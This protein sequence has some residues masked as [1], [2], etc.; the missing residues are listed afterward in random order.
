MKR[1][2]IGPIV[3]AVPTGKWHRPVRAERLVTRTDEPDSLAR[4]PRPHQRRRHRL[5]KREYAVPILPSRDL[6]ETL[7]FFERLGF[8][9]Q[10]FPPEVR[11]YI[12][13][14]RGRIQL[15]LLAAPTTDPLANTASCYVFVAD[16]DR[17]NADWREIG[18]AADPDTGSRLEAPMNTDY[19]MREF[20][21][22]D[23]S[24]NHVR[25]GSVLTQ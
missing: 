6:R 23:P 11:D 5:P 16:A 15:H 18:V 10:A 9:N 25:V 17:V 1:A 19:G 13:L 21:V 7:A 3:F 4:V 20:V 8:Q 14:A 22:I 2:S 12:I 24:G